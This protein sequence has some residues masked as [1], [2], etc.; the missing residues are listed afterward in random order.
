MAIQFSDDD[1]DVMDAAEFAAF[2][3]ALCA[4]E[5]GTVCTADFHDCLVSRTQSGCSVAALMLITC[6]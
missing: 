5:V 6:G 1:D 4:A 3:A 2:D